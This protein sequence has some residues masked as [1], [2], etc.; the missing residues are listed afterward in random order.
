MMQSGG[1]IRGPATATSGGT[2]KVE[3]DSGGSVSVTVPGQP[4]TKVPVQG[5][6]ATIPVPSNLPAGTLV[7][8]VVLGRIPPE[9]ITVEIVELS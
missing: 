8:I 5:G 3:V 9:G 1:G 6:A 4:P 2:I 7:Q